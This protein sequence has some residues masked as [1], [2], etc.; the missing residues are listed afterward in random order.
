MVIVF[1]EGNQADFDHGP[2]R[3]DAFEGCYLEERQVVVGDDFDVESLD[4]LPV[5]CAV[6]QNVEA[7][8]NGEL[9]LKG[10]W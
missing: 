7:E 3:D 8:G 10:E 9:Q 6:G 5:L 4:Q 2:Q 1:V